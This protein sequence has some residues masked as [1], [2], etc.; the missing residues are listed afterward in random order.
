MQSSSSSF[1]I[2]TNMKSQVLVLY[3]PFLLENKIGFVYSFLTNLM[4]GHSFLSLNWQIEI[5]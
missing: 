2:E 1:K 3:Q 4:A 5:G